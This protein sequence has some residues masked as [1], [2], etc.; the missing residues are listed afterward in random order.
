M[1]PAIVLMM[2]RAVSLPRIKLA[3]MV[4]SM[5][6][7]WKPTPIARVGARTSASCTR[8]SSAQ[9]GVRFATQ[10]TF[11]SLALIVELFQPLKTLSAT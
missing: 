6:G 5:N 7:V 11:W 3:Y 9:L 2:L 1:D 8:A 4:A 10:V